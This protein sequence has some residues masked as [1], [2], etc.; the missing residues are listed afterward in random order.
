MYF[1][2]AAILPPSIYIYYIEFIKEV[3][4]DV[5]TFLYRIFSNKMFNQ[6]VATD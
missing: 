5:S 6:S 2:V 3:N 1:L 4:F